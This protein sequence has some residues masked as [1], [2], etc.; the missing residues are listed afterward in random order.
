MLTS[1]VSTH[2]HPFSTLVLPDPSGFFLLRGLHHQCPSPGGKMS[3]ILIQ[4]CST[5]FTAVHSAHV[6]CW[7]PSAK[8]LIHSHQIKLF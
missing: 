6:F 7:I 1:Q 5:K 4:T 2:L 8:T 3:Q